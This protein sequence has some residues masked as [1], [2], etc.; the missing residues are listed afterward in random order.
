MANIVLFHSVLGLRP[1]VKAAAEKLRKAGHTVFTPD[2]YSGKVFDDMEAADTKF[3]EI[4]ISEMM[5]RT[6]QSA[7]AL[8]EDLVYA[9]FSN[10]GAS[11][12]LL[13]ATRKGAKGCIL[14]HAALPLQ[15]LGLNNWSPTIPVQI[16][17]AAEDPRRNDEWIKAFSD[18]VQQA[19]AKLEF[20]EYACK[21][22][23]FTDTDLQD[24]NHDAAELLWERVLEFL[25]GI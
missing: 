8:P 11:A 12:E 22:H 24:Y 14:F 3:Q 9:G 19:G 4:G 5:S 18:S 20:Y 6:M 21:G 10:G 7:S 23:L 16:H 13:A 2:L 1:A 15:A 25:R 17:Y